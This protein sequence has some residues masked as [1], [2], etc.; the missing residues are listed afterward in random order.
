MIKVQK[1]EKK[2]Q[3]ESTCKGV[4]RE[5]NGGY[6]MVRKRQEEGDMDQN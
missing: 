5:G 2:K 3:V 4:D 6:N 1:K